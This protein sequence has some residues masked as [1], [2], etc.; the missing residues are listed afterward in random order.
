M[1]VR[2]VKCKN[3]KQAA[4]LLGKQEARTVCNNTMLVRYGSRIGVVLHGT[5]VVTYYLNGEFSIK[6]GGFY[7]V[8]T[9]D[10]INR[11]SDAGL[12]QHKK[13]WY[14]SGEDGKAIP[15]VDGMR[16]KPDFKVWIVPERD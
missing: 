10:R 6:T 15:F 12:Y 2:E 7:T 14:V 1:N 16:R 4:K 8:T 9:K 3:Y 13:E 5:T 11:F